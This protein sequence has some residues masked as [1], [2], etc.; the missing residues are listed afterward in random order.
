MRVTG[1]MIRKIMTSLCVSSAVVEVGLLSSPDMTIET[2]MMMDVMDETVRA[3]KT[4]H[5]DQNSFFF[6]QLF[7]SAVYSFNLEKFL[8]LVHR[9]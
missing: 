4:C 8:L 7:R 2:L 3:E 1:A 5:S 6:H 9:K